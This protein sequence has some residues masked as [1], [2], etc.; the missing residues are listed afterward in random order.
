MKFRIS[1]LQS[2]YWRDTNMLWSFYRL[3]NAGGRAFRDTCLEKFSTRESDGDFELRRKMS[4]TPAFAKVAV[5]KVLRSIYQRMSEI[6]RVGGSEAY[7]NAMDG[8][9]GGVDRQGTS[10]NSFMGQEVLIELGT[11]GRVGIFVDKA[12]K[13]SDLLLFN[14]RN[15]PYMY[16][17]ASEDI[18]NYQCYYEN[19][20]QIFV[21][22]L[23]KMTDYTYD[24]KTG[25]ETGV[26]DFYRRFWINGDG[27]VQ[28]DDYFYDSEKEEDVIKRTKVTQLRQIPFVLGLLSESLY[29]DI[30]DYQSGLLNLASADFNYCFR[31]NF[32]FLTE[33]QDQ[34]FNAAFA[35][36]ANAPI[37]ANGIVNEELTSTQAAVG[38]SKGRV[39]GKNLERPGFIAPPSEPLLASMEKQKQMQAEIEKMLHLTITNLKPTQSNV[40]KNEDPSVNVGLSYIGE[41]LQYIENC[42]ARFWNM[43]ENIPNSKPAQVNYPE[44]YE[45]KSDEDRIALAKDLVKLKGAAPSITFQKQIGIEISETL[46]GGKVDLEKLRK[47]QTEIDTAEYI[48]SDCEEI[49]KDIENGL[50]DHAT[51]S[52]ARGYTG[53]DVVEKAKMENIERLSAI[54]IAQAKGKGDGANAARGVPKTAQDHTAE[55]EKELADATN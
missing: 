26:V 45:L 51:A 41:T 22:L 48:T 24:E 11:T 8:L 30:G 3:C 1:S 16:V 46:L 6:R 19:N 54:A 27:F 13:E 17:F 34:A 12:E 50:V 47:I 10:M 2:Q 55:D 43:Y 28:C 21:N 4:F 23:V 33:Q 7:Q 53:K 35:S 31:S 42:I 9:N 32:P 20:M 29:T 52:L 36:R 37:N 18:Y 5:H 44:K 49:A 38:P 25:F 40:P 15:T 14:K 39:Y